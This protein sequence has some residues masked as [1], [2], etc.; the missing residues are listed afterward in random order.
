MKIYNFPIVKYGGDFYTKSIEYQ[1]IDLDYIVSIGSVFPVSY[2]GNIIGESHAYFTIYI[3]LGQPIII[4]HYSG[5]MQTCP[6]SLINRLDR[7][8]MHLIE[9]WKNKD[10]LTIGETYE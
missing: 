8:R 7:E 3:K 2:T 10:N 5:H 4:N 6:D 1:L 9:A